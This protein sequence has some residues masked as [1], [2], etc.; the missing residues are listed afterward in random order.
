MK[1]LLDAPPNGEELKE[2]RLAYNMTRKEMSELLGVGGSTVY[3]Y[4]TGRRFNKHKS[5]YNRLLK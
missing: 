1:K 5:R 2:I 4:E 3:F